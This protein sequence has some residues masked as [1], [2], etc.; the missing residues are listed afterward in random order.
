MPMRED[1]R[2]FD[3]RSYASGETV[4]KCRLDLAPQ[5]PW[6]CPENCPSYSK[7]MM[8]AGWTYGSLAPTAPIREPAQLD[9]SASAILDEA[10][11]L[12]NSFGPGIIA[13]FAEREAATNASRWK[14]RKLGGKAKKPKKGKGK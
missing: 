2:H 12:L 10:E 13:E 4:R 3:S 6:R 8:D 1:C 7:R 9:E 14:R 11:E 5:A